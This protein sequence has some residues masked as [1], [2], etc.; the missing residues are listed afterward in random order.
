VSKLRQG[1]SLYT[2]NNSV[3]SILDASS[4]AGDGEKKVVD[5]PVKKMQKG[6]F[7]FK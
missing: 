4:L 2:K 6:D 5:S 3:G 7:I 1:T